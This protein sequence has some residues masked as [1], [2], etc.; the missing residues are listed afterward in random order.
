MLEDEKRM[1][2]W[3]AR[4]GRREGGGVYAFLPCISAIAKSIFSINC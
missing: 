1:G 2:K 3:C 4:V